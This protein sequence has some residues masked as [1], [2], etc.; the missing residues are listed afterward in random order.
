[1]ELP[2]L[3]NPTD[4]PDPTEAE[5]IAAMHAEIDADLD[6]VEAASTDDPDTFFLVEVLEEVARARTKFPSSNL[7]LAALT[8]EVGEL[9]KAM[10]DEPAENVRKEAVQVAAMALR[11]AIDGDRSFDES[12]ERRGLDPLG[13]AQA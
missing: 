10:L 9:A 11:V 12:R 7:K 6:A 5:T 4:A 2:V 8:E 1:M 13:N 3:L